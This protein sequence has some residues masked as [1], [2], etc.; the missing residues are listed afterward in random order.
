[1]PKMTDFQTSLGYFHVFHVVE[2][3]K[4]ILRTNTVKNET[5][6]KKSKNS[7]FG[8]FLPILVTFYE[9]KITFWKKLVGGATKTD[10]F[11]EVFEIYILWGIQ[12]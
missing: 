7:I 1:M 9:V 10:L 6:S 8:Q 12:K 3:I 4:D 2:H 11:D 5:F